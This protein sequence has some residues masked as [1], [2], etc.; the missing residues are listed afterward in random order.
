[1]SGL[2]TDVLLKRV[3]GLRANSLAAVVMLLI[4]YGL[5][6]AVNLYSSLP[7]SDRGKSLFPAFGAAVGNGPVLLTLHAL[8]GTLLLVTGM[9]AVIRATRLSAPPLIALST[10]A[11]ASILGAW[12]S[13]A[14]FV[15]RMKNGSS[16]A[17]ALATALAILCYAVTLF[18]LGLPARR[19]AQTDAA[20]S[21]PSATAS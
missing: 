3:G 11:F 16:L 21:S 18:L 13:G 12:M 9:A 5:G 2:T 7:T 14:D 19:R 10:I 8:L 4:Q 17:M 15:A 1:M 20:E 6:M